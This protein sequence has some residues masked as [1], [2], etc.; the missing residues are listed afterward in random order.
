MFK[1]KIFSILLL[2]NLIHMN[3]NS[4]VIANWLPIDNSGPAASI[5]VLIEGKFFF[6]GTGFFISV[7]PENNDEKYVDPKSM[8]LI[9][10]DHVVTSNSVGVRIPVTETFAEMMKDNQGVKFPMTD[11]KYWMIDGRTIRGEI[12]LIEGENFYRNKDRDLA[13][14]KVNIPSASE[15]EN[16][17][18]LISQI[19]VIGRN[20]I[21]LEAELNIGQEIYFVGFPFGMGTVQGHLNSGE[22]ASNPPIPIVRS[23]MISWKDRNNPYFLVDAMVYPGNSGGPVYTKSTAFNTPVKLIGMVHAY[24]F[25]PKR[26]ELQLNL[27]LAKV[28]WMN[29]IFDLIE[30]WESKK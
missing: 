12:E 20:S 4:Q 2:L 11:G 14:I 25:D 1:P 6:S 26:P 19:S 17:V 28:S 18:L 29:N 8:Y 15:S 23:G 22:F 10:C 16:G 5:E 3:S 30:E 13:A 21:S 27:G 9:T 24:Y 7:G